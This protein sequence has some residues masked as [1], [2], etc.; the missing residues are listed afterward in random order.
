MK[1]FGS[2][3]SL[4]RISLAVLFAAQWLTAQAIAESCTSRSLGGF[5]PAGAPVAAVS[6]NP[7]QI[8]LFVTGNDGKVYNSWWS[9]GSGW[10]SINSNWR[11]IGGFFPAG[12]PVAAVLRNPNQI[13]LFVIAGDGKVY[14]SW[15]ST[16]SVW[17]DTD[18]NWRPIG[19]LF[20]PGASIA[21]ISR[22]SNHVDLFTTGN[23]G[24]VYTIWSQ[25]SEWSDFKDDW[26]PIGGR[27]PVGAPVAV[28]AR[29][30]NQLDLF[31]TG[32]DGKVYTSW[33][34]AGSGWSGINNN[35]RPI[36]GLFPA[37][38]PVAAVSRDSNQ[39]D[40]FVTGDDG[41]VYTSWWSPGSG[42]SGVNSNWRPIGGMFPAG[43][44]VAAISRNPS[45]I[46]LFITGDDGKVYTS[47]WSQE[48]G[49]SGSNKNWR[50]I[51]GFSARAEI[52]VVSRSP[53]QLDLFFTG[54]EGKKSLVLTSWWSQGSD[55]SSHCP[56][57]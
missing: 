41:K 38:A 52:A 36:G 13:D 8:D 15:W 14:T 18:T 53:N 43:A 29:N 44:P 21:A 40:L 42:W 46:D 47:W 9:P 23:D 6:R 35:W 20:P 37:G 4:A 22:S 16:G 25:G 45:L 51:G 55:W 17:S 26:R 7:N 50:P 11:P 27:F 31:A 2:T 49:W 28:V 54:N 30:A 19:G 3:I 24:K 10:S 1:K 33:W 56:S 12:A 48:T 34:S 39:L 5:F 32:T 57:P